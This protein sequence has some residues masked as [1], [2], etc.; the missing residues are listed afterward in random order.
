MS[1]PKPLVWRDI[2]AGAIP[3]S[4]ISNPFTISAAAPTEACREYLSIDKGLKLSPEWHFKI[5]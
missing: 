4:A 5:A 2:N 3:K 1:T